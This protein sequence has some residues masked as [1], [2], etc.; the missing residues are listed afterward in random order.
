MV[1]EILETKVKKAIINID[2]TMTDINNVLRDLSMK[3]CHII[4]DKKYYYNMLKGNNY[5]K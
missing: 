3:L 1:K 4:K 5:L 2:K